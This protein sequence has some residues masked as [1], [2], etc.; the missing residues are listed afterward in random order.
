ME[1]PSVFPL[2][3]GIQLPRL[4]LP[5]PLLL[6]L[7]LAVSGA[8]LHLFRV[9]WRLRH[10]PGPFW[11][12]FTN[13]QRVLWV[14]TGRSHEIHRAVHDRYGE[15]VRFAPNMVSLA[16]PAWIPQLYPI[17]P[18]FPKVRDTVVT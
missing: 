18:G 5:L 12:N 13:L 14:K 1:S 11:A 6:A 8:G 3:H 15:V 16:N 4:P 9:W 7:A 17:R 10:I 2:G